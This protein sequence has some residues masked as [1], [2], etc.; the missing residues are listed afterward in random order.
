M[1]SRTHIVTALGLLLMIATLATDA[2][3]GATKHPNGS[4]AKGVLKGC[5]NAGVCKPKNKDNYSL[6]LN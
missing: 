1:L 2:V 6:W 5:V 3:A 4:I